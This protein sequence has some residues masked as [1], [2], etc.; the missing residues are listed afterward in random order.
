MYYFGVP[1]LQKKFCHER[2]Q[3]NLLDLKWCL[4]VFRS[5]LQTFDIKSHA[6][7]IFRGWMHYIEVPNLQKKF[8][9]E[10]IQFNLLD[11]KWCLAVFRSIL[12]TFDIKNHAKLIF[13]G[14]MHYIE[15][16]N[17]QKKFCYERIQFNLL[18]LKWCLAVFRSILQTFDIKNHAKL[19]FRS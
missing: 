6:K 1:Y 13:R 14:W 16:P 18:D 12:Q 3:F 4:A 2:I 19:I 15:V 8:C 5:I 17:L 10:R 7:L 11:L 9:H